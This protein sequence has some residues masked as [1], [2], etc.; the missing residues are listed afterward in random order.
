LTAREVIALIGGHNFT[1]IFELHRVFKPI[2]SIRPHED[3]NPN[4]ADFDADIAI[5]TLAE[6]IGFNDYIQPICLFDSIN[7]VDATKGTIVGYGKTEDPTIEHTLTPRTLEVSIHRNEQCFLKFNDLASLSS[8][9]TYCGG[10]ANSSGACK[11][12]SGHGLFVKHYENY[13]LHGIVSSSLLDRENNCLTNYYS[14]LTNVQKYTKWIEEDGIS[15]CGVMSLST[16]LIQGG[17]SS[18]AQQFPWTV[19]IIKENNK[20]S[21]GAIVSKS[22]VIASAFFLGKVDTTSG[23]RLPH[24][25]ELI[26]IHIES[27]DETKDVAAVTLFPKTDNETGTTLNIIAI[28]TLKNL[29]TFSDVIKPICI[30]S[31]HFDFERDRYTPLYVSGYGINENEEYS[32]VR[33]HVRYTLLSQAQCLESFSSH[34]AALKSARIFC[35][36]GTNTATACTGD[37]LIFGR[38]NG[39]WVLRGI[40]VRSIGFKGKKTCNPEKPHL[41]EDTAR[42]SDWIEGVINH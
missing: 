6:E 10:D 28:L 32:Q 22:H 31:Q 20:F 4:T 41:Y 9:R 25:A 11:G 23:T 16:G 13:Y 42:F 30:T 26:K 15:A 27:C 35:A 19:K 8:S 17:Y 12:D 34:A 33:K 7:Y 36:I 3:Y 40:S 24:D 39:V 5:L 37:S 2:K 29:F 18:T 1:D 14:I 38:L 21:T